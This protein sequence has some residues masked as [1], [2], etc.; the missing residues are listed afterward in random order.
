MTSD[1]FLQILKNCLAPDSLTAAVQQ[2]G[3]P[4]DKCDVAYTKNGEVGS[5]LVE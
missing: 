2:P 4:Y 1:I 3:A 5:A